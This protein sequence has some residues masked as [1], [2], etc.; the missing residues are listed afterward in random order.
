[1][2][3]VVCI[4]IKQ[5]KNESTIQACNDVLINCLII[6]LATLFRSTSPQVWAYNN[7]NY[8]ELWNVSPLQFHSAQRRTVDNVVPVQ[9]NHYCETYTSLARGLTKHRLLVRIV[10]AGATTLSQY[11][12]IVFYQLLT[13]NEHRFSQIMRIKVWLKISL[14]Y[15]DLISRFREMKRGFADNRRV[16]MRKKML[17]FHRKRS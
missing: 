16:L 14:I 5:Y 17:F 11:M 3:P 2:T 7:N 15:V 8:M 12:Y 13:P 9:K 6:L 10:S 4:Y 1:M